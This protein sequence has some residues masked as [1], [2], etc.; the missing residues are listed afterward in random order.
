MFDTT[1]LIATDALNVVRKPIQFYRNME[2]SGG[3]SDPIMFVTAM[4]IMAGVTIST[5]SF[6]GFKVANLITTG[7]SASVMIPLMII[8]G[9]FIGAALLLCTWRLLGSQASFEA[10]F[11]CVAYTSAIIP[12]ALILG[13]TPYIG[14][15]IKVVWPIYLIYIAS[16]E[17]LSSSFKWPG[18]YHYI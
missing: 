3:F 4:A 12:I 10:A 15:L 9:S 14:I 2:K 17:A 8:A 16:I 6:C 18:R 5:L 13:L 7:Y 1:L 11:R